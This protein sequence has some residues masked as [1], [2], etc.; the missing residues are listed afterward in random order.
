VV[1][2]DYR[3]FNAMTVAGLLFILAALLAIAPRQ[4]GLLDSMGRV[5]L[6]ALVFVYGASHLGLLAH[7]SRGRLEL[8]GILVLIAE[9]A[10]RVVGRPHPGVSVP[11]RAAGLALSFGLTIGAG[12]WLGTLAEITRG[13]G[14]LAAALIVAAVSAGAI[15]ADAVAEDLALPAASFRVGR[16][17]FLDRA[18]PAIFPAAVYYHY[19]AFFL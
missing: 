14:A 8:Y 17:A 6:G 5:L 7:Q 19:L 15:V 4:S 9:L 13:Q 1:I 12:T 18:M 2:D 16:G 10:Q 3:L 11:R